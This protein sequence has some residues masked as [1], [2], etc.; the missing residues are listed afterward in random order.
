M[1]IQY[2]K[3]SVYNLSSICL[4]ADGILRSRF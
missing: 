2:Q 3:K 4:T 1:D